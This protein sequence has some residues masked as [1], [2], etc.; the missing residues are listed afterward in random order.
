MKFTVSLL[1]FLLLLLLWQNSGAQNHA[2]NVEVDL[3]TIGVGPDYW[4]AFGHTA[5][6]VKSSS[7][8][9]VYGFG[10]FDFNEE[11]FFLKFAKGESRYFL[12]IEPT[13]QALESAIESGR[14]VWKQKLNLDHEEKAKLIRKLNYLA[15][16]ENRYYKYDYFRNNCT[17]RIRDIIDD[18]THGEILTSLHSIENG[19]SWYDLTFPAKNQSWMN[20]GIAIAYG[21]P[22][23]KDRNQ[24]QLSIFPDVFAQDLE[25]IK[26]EWVGK[27]EL[28]HQ[29]KPEESVFSQYS[30]WKTH[31]AMFAIV[32]LMLILLHY[33]KTAM[34]AVNSWLILQSLVG[35]G[36]LLLWF[37]SSHS[38]AANN[39][40]V[41]LF[42]PLAF[43]FLFKTLRKEKLITFYV[44]INMLWLIAAIVF[45]S[46]YLFGFM[47]INVI[48]AN[49]MILKSKS[50]NL[51]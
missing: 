12:G 4:E 34:I 23:Y 33:G 2:D 19:Q 22:A 17:S 41:L 20:L 21:L 43:L 16:P 7:Y 37:F 29:P 6:R 10:Y 14:T 15:Q 35:I 42:F 44:I 32:I 9:Y 30:F 38:V 47:M 3:I 39:V 18:V 45:T 1:I 50:K 25:N 51:V 48:V 24:W 49:Q 8:D 11:D 26:A 36:L 28:V 5:I 40:N 27:L 31:Y 46:I 13:Q